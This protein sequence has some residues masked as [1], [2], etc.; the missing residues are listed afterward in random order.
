MDLAV[1]RRFG[2]SERLSLFFRIE[3]FNVFNH[4]MFAPPSA[5]FNNFLQSGGFGRITSTLNNFVGGTGTSLSP[6]Y[7][8]GG[9]R[10]GQLSLKLQF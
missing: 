6:L 3:Y 2:L 7:E 10:S 8:I 1:S 5:N 9:P 4:P